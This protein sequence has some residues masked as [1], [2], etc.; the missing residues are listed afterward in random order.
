MP[1]MTPNMGASPK[2]VNRSRQP[3][4][5]RV[6]GQQSHELRTPLNASIGFLE[7]LAERLFGELNEKQEE[8]LKDITPRDSTSYL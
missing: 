1:A 7:I 4:Q 5:V 8:Y 3:A 6:P 2:T